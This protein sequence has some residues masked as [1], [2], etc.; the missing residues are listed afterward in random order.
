[1]IDFIRFKTTWKNLLLALLFSQIL[2]CAANADAFSF[3]I[4]PVT[5]RPDGWGGLVWGDPP[6]KLGESRVRTDTA[7]DNKEAYIREGETTNL[8]AAAIGRVKYHFFDGRLAAVDFT[9]L[10]QSEDIPLLDYASREFGDIQI[11]SADD[12]LCEWFDNEIEI[13]LVS[14]PNQPA[15]LRI[16]S[17]S[18]P[19]MGYYAPLFMKKP[20]TNKPDGYAG[21]SWGDGPGSLGE[22]GIVKARDSSRGI[23]VYSLDRDMPEFDGLAVRDARFSFLESGLFLAEL[24]FEDS[25]T[26]AELVEYALDRFGG[27]TC[28]RDDGLEYIWD[29]GE[30]V[31]SLDISDPVG[32]R[33]LFGP[34]AHLAAANNPVR[35]VDWITL[36]ANDFGGGDGTEKNPYLIA[37]PS[38]LARVAL[39]VNDGYDSRDV[40]FKLTNDIDISGKEW[41]PI[42]GSNTRKNF[43][44]RLDGNKHAISGLRVSGDKSQVGLFRTLGS[45]A[46]ISRV[47]IR[48]ARIN[49]SNEAGIIAGRSAGVIKDC[50]VGGTVS[51]DVSVG[52]VAGFLTGDII[53]S[54]SDAE[55]MGARLVGGIAGGSKAGT[56]RDSISAGKIEGGDYVGGIIGRNGDGGNVAKSRSE[57]SVRGNTFVGGITGHNLGTV[58]DCAAGGSISGRLWTGGIAGTNEEAASVLNC[59][60]MGNITGKRITGGV[61]GLNR[62]GGIVN[63][64]AYDKKK[65]GQSE[66]IGHDEPFSSY[67]ARKIKSDPEFGLQIIVYAIGALIMSLSLL[68]AFIAVMIMKGAKGLTIPLYV[69]LSFII[70]LCVVFAWLTLK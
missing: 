39:I 6:E 3:A 4:K 36:A 41:T 58:T 38:Q 59:A 54:Y 42:G 45:E 57:S 44:G 22:G 24:A 7:E 62:Y 8:G 19:T 27:A 55:V 50:I 13:Y 47:T 14:L 66:E 61:V 17:S 20:I 65:T 46:V 18:V 15:V 69:S 2:L 28:V 35:V 48:D 40:H 25:L 26:E 52:G 34:T 63:Q 12:D 30:F 64:N 49:G 56:V 16:I 10:D 51:G 5:N 11:V 21:L 67:F 33:M 43:N 68:C 53:G 60:V 37:T 29:D 32:V 1:M 70:A 9:S 31:M 23:A